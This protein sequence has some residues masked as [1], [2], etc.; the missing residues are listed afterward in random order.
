[1]P[2]VYQRG[3]VYLK[4][5]KTKKWYGKFRVYYKDREGQEVCQTKRVVLGAKS[6]LKKWEAEKKLEQIAAV[7][8]GSAGQTPTT[9]LAD[10][11]VTFAWFVEE[12]YLPMRR[13]RWRV[14]TKKSTEFEIR[15]YLVSKFGPRPLR[16]LD[17]FQLQMWLNKLAEKYADTVVRH[18]Y[19]NLRA[20]LKMARKLKFLVEN[21]AEDLEMPET[22]EVI[23]P[24]LTAQQICTLIDGVENLR[25]K[26]LLCVGIFCATRA[27]E[28]FGLTWKSYLGD[29]L[30]VQSTAYEGEF[31]EGKVKTH[32]SKTT[33]PLPM[34]VRPVIEAWKSVCPDTSPDALMFPTFGRGRRTG[35]TVPFHSKNFLRCKIGPIAEKLGIPKSLVTF[36]VMRRTLGTDMQGFGTLKDAQMVLR[37]ASIKTTADVYMQE[38]AESTVKAINARTR[39]ILTEGRKTPPQEPAA[40][41]RNK[42]SGADSVT[43]R[44]NSA[45][46]GRQGTGNV[47]N[48]VAIR[49]NTRSRSLEKEEIERKGGNLRVYETLKTDLESQRAPMGS[50]LKFATS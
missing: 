44:R 28:T 48:V 2:M 13:G 5:I 7:A 38:I 1:M 46:V 18:S 4:G 3:N 49:A 33:V 36:Q 25:D 26:A 45:S 42:D 37:H 16:E 6:E 11:S 24:T 9:L 43:V 40:G 17:P 47:A 19:V 27:S 21:P 32:S 20:I 15:H 8:N 50:D 35:M 10:D 30:L 39:A 22:R 29:R 14:A 23:R 12:R 34:D 31:Y 41:S